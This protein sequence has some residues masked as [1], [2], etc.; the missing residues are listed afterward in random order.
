MEG[1]SC[2]SSSTEQLNDFK[3]T[4]ALCAS[5][6]ILT[7]AQ[8]TPKAQETSNEVQLYRLMLL[9][10]ARERNARFGTAQLLYTGAHDR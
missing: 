1:S 8:A 7:H 9:A 5:S 4:L 6:R 10:G 2:P 3:H